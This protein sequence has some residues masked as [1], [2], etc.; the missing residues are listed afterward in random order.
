MQKNSIFLALIISM[1]IVTSAEARDYYLYGDK[2]EGTKFRTQI[3]TSTISLSKNYARLADKEKRL[4]RDA[5]PDLSESDNPPYPK[6]GIRTIL[7]PYVEKYRWHGSNTSG[8]LLVDIGRDGSVSNVRSNV[9][10]GQWIDA[11]LVWYLSQVIENIE[12]DPALCSGTPCA[13]TFRIEL[14][15]IRNPD[16]L[17]Q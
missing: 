16:N 11:E 17:M 10:Q 4:V 3:Y 14:R 1:L 15:P 13:M 5:Y 2:K 9:D 8:F 12:F 6:K 7:K